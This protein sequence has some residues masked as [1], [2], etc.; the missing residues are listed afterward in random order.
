MLLNRVVLYFCFVLT[1]IFSSVY[2]Q[3]S[4]IVEGKKTT[5]LLND[6]STISQLSKHPESIYH[7]QLKFLSRLSESPQEQIVFYQKCLNELIKYKSDESL[8]AI[9]ELLDVSVYNNFPLS[10]DAKVIS[11]IRDD[12]SRVWYAIKWQDASKDKKIETAL[13]GVMPDPPVRLSTRVGVEKISELG[14]MVRPDLYKLLNNSSIT[15]GFANSRGF[16]Y[17]GMADLAM[18]MATNKLFAPT[19][20]EFE[21]IQH[22]GGD[23]GKTVLIQYG[24]KKKDLRFIPLVLQW[25]EEK[26]NDRMRLYYAIATL[27]ELG[28]NVQENGD[29]ELV[30][31]VIS[32]C[33]FVASDITENKGTATDP[34][35]LGMMHLALYK[36]GK[37]IK[38]LDYF[39]H[40]LASFR[41]NKFLENMNKNQG[42]SDDPFAMA[43]NIAG[44][45]IREWSK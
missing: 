10:Q 13:F 17:G 39:S 26:R 34:T 43:D 16:P 44:Q 28:K 2:G 32:L 18:L 21:E 29:T 37:N 11:S 35:L 42:K 24:I 8:G 19:D 4:I 12:A 9:E 22:G 6:M 31:G 40:Y 25:M 1:S 15:Y 20:K 33:R 5:D 14:E 23:F 27:Y 38:T 45:A 41:K 3:D 7:I 30:G 36:F